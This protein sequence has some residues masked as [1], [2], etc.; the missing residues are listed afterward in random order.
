VDRV[1]TDL[2]LEKRGTERG[3]S[4]EPASSAVGF[5]DV[6]LAIIERIEEEKKTA[7]QS[8]EDQ[9]QVFS[10]RLTNLDFD[11]QF[12]MIKQAI[13]TTVTDYI[14]EV[15]AGIDELHGL[16]RALSEAEDERTT[17]KKNAQD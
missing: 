16:R 10:E 15:E 12:V 7:Y 14:A 3:S 4:N 5:D 8:V 6:E 2:D 1:A 9:M 17:F 11:G 13:A